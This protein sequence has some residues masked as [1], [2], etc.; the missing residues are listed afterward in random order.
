MQGQICMCKTFLFY[1]LFVKLFNTGKTAFFFFLINLV[2][3]LEKRVPSVLQEE[4]LDFRG[5]LN[6]EPLWLFYLFVCLFFGCWCF[7]RWQLV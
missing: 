5:Q 6:N 7:L 1:Q 4:Q 3:L 2:A